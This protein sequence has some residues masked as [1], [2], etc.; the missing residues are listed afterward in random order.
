M[1]F[2]PRPGFGGFTHIF[3]LIIQGLFFLATLA[4]IVGVLFLL[5]RFLLIAT[6]AARI[7]VDKNAPVAVAETPAKPAAS[8]TSAAA[9]SAA[10]PSTTSTTSRATR[11]T[12]A[13]PK[14][15]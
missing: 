12:K 1:I 3:A 9:P 15:K 2:P 8:A 10:A 6:R 4:I 14:A 5:V 7:Y 11:T 13:P